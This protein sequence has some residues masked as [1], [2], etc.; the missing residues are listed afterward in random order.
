MPGDLG[1]ME[2]YLLGFREFRWSWGAKQLLHQEGGE[3]T[4]MA[5]KFS[6]PEAVIHSILGPGQ[7]A[8]DG[9]FRE[10]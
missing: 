9:P 7:Q 3:D 1:R 8:D 4:N 5:P 2:P 10:A 6:P